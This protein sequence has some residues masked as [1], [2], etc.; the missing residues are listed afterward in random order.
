MIKFIHHH[1]KKTY[2]AL[3]LLSVEVIM[4]ALLFVLSFVIFIFIVDRIF[5]QRTDVFD[6]RVFNFLS[7][8]VTPLNNSMMQSITFF[9][10]ATFLFPANILLIIWFAFIQKHRWYS[11]K[12]PVISITSLSLMIGLKT[13]FNRPRPLIPLL[14]A[15]SGLSFPSGHSLT[16]MTFYGLIAYIV[17]ERIKNPYIK[18]IT[19]TALLIFIL[20]IGFSRI[21]LRVHYASDVAAG[22]SIGFIWL[23]ISLWALRHLERFT[24]KKIDPVVEE[25]KSEVAKSPT[26]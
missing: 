6:L 16:S 11:I 4:I 3:L 7:Q 9:G 13:L 23:V 5:L 20:L 1:V 25:N 22:F 14:D 2:A 15:A 24:S 17:W 26:I 8:Y 21:Y 19:I 10:T 12:I 18:W